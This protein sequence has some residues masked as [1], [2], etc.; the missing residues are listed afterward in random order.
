MVIFVLGINELCLVEETSLVCVCFSCFFRWLCEH[1]LAADDDDD[2]DL[3]G[4]ETE[5]E[6]KAAEE[7]ETAKKPKES[8]PLYLF[9]YKHVSYGEHMWWVYNDFSFY[10]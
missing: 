4:D 2:M 3:F 5:E 1:A 7:R 6:K 9:Y 10:S 8:K